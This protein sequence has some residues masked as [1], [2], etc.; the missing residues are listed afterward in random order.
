[1][2]GLCLSAKRK[3]LL[4][5]SLMVVISP[6]IVH[7]SLETH[8]M[9]MISEYGPLNLYMSYNPNASGQYVALKGIEGISQGE[10]IER[11]ISFVIHNK[12]TTIDII[13]NKVLILFDMRLYEEAGVRDIKMSKEIVVFSQ[14]I[15]I[16]VFMLGFVGL[17]RY[18]RR[19]HNAIVSPVLSYLVL[20][21]LFSIFT[22]R[23]RLLVEPLLV[24]YA[25]ILISQLIEK[26]KELFRQRIAERSAK[27][28][29]T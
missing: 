23:F 27:V 7:K 11:S 19:E 21:I 16:G 28:I 12:M 1:M 4:I 26:T 10:L 9:V 22:M 14:I 5:G 8:K 18:Y 6:W 20:I 15:H 17:S 25:G 3:V 24:I 13:I 29:V 2:P